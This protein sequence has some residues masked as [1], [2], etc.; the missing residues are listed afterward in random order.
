VPS[1]AGFILCATKGEVWPPLP[2]RRTR[3]PAKAILAF[4]DDD[5]PIVPDDSGGS[6]S[7][8]APRQRPYLARRL[9][10]LVVGVG[11]IIL[12]VLAFRACLDSR[13][14]RGFENYNS[15]L[16]SIAT[17]S[18]QLSEE[19]FG[20]LR[21]PGNLTD[22]AFKAEVSADRGTAENLLQRVQGLDAP[23]E[24]AEA[25]GELELAFELRRDG[26]AGVGDQIS[27]AL[28]SD[29]QARGEA[30]E[31]IATYMRYFL[32][33]DVLYQRAR[34][35]IDA[36]LDE[37]EIP[38]AEDDRLPDQ[39]FLP[40]PTEDWLDDTTLATTLSGAAGGANCG[41]GIHGLSR[42]NTVINDTELFTDTSTTVS[43]GGPYVITVDVQN[44]GDTEETDVAVEYSI[45]GGTDTI[46]GSG[47]VT[48]IEPGAVQSADLE[49]DPDPPTGEELTLEVNVIPVCDEELTDDN[50]GTFPVVFE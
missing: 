9:I 41:P 18:Q 7:Y 47:T 49:I 38:V 11:F 24:V 14:E 12:L 29:G 4:L 37:E 5:D 28:G 46:E 33:S 43:G 35:S 26:I 25:Q 17:E 13:K 48:R 21:D 20:R 22:L 31:R 30:L 40:D 10:A 15:D 50:V 44:D 32:S 19:F 8:G 2:G 16:S 42:V 34:E 27:T 1:A 45:S 36:T 39:N 3:P 23:G 6:G